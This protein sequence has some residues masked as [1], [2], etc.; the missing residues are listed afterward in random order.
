MF[1]VVLVGCGGESNSADAFVS[2]QQIQILGQK[3]VAHALSTPAGIDCGPS[4]M[5]CSH[6]FPSRS[7][8]HLHIEQVDFACGTVTLEERVYD[9]SGGTLPVPYDADLRVSDMD[10]TINCSAP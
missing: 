1:V 8:V 4:S 5:Q 6:S 2:T 3:T 9:G 7:F 10:I